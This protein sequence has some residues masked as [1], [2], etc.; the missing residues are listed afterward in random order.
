MLD[1]QRRSSQGSLGLNKEE[2]LEQLILVTGYHAQDL[3]HPRHPQT[4][5]HSFPAARHAEGSFINSPESGQSLYREEVA[6]GA[7]ASGVQAG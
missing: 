6:S 5:L 1:A 4:S 3:A 7:G 2:L